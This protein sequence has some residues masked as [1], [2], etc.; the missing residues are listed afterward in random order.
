MHVIGAAQASAA[1][2]ALHPLESVDLPA[3]PLP[4]SDAPPLAYHFTDGHIHAIVGTAPKSGVALC[5]V[6]RSVLGSKSLRSRAGAAPEPRQLH[7]LRRGLAGRRLV[8]GLW[9]GLHFK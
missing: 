2:F 6:I 1:D 7:A 8:A 5:V 4:P 9:R 3:H